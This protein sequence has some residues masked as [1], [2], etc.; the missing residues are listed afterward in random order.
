[1]RLSFAVAATALA[2]AVVAGSAPAKP[3]LPAQVKAMKGIELAV[4]RGSIDRGSAATYRAAVNRAARLIRNLP[5]AR[6]APISAALNQVAAMS[7]KL[8]APRAKAVFGQLA[9]NSSYFASKGPPGDGA[10]VRDADGVVYRYFSGR[11]L[12]FHP[13]ANFGALNSA[14]SRGY[15][16]SATRLA[17][18][19]IER[20]VGVPGGGK[21]WEYYF[22]YSGGRAP[23][24]SGM[25]QAVAAQAIASVAGLNEEKSAAFMAAARGAYRAI[26]GRLV[27]NSSSGLWVKLYG[28][29]RLTVLNAQ[30]QAV[31]SLGAYADASGDSAVY[32]MAS[33]LQ[34]SAAAALSRFDTGYWSYYALPS[35][36]S[37]L[38]YQRYVVQMLNQLRGSD[39]R[40]DSAAIRFA[41]YEKQPPAFKL[42]NTN[43]G[44]VRFWLSKPSSVEMKSGAGRTKRYLLK[45]GWYKL[46]WKLPKKAGAYG[47]TVSARDWASNSASFSS[48]PIVRTVTPS[49]KVWKVK[50]KSLISQKKTIMDAAEAGVT[51]RIAATT[52]TLGQPS[53]SV[54]AGL[55]DPSQVALASL[56]G[57]NTARYS[58]TWPGPS[59]A[60]PDPALVESLRANP[61]DKR[62][63]AELVVDPTLLTDDTAIAALAGYARS[64]AEQLPTIGDLLIGPAP[65]NN[66]TDLYVNVLGAI[67]DAV[68]LVAP[69][70]RVAGVIDGTTTPKTTLSSLGSSYG[71]SGRA[72]P[73]M[74]ELAFRPAPALQNGDWTIDNYS[75]LTT[76]LTSAFAGTAQPVSSLPILVDGVATVTGIPPE[77]VALYP[78]LATGTDEGTQ[79]TAYTH[80]LQAAV[81]MPTVSGVL[82]R[83]LVDHPGTAEQPN[84][85]DQSGLYYADGTAKSSADSLR[86]TGQSAQRGILRPCPGV[87]MPVLASTL[88]FPLELPAASP[89]AVLLACTRDCLYLV[90]LER[91]DGKPVRAQRG[92][93]AGGPTPTTVQLPKGTALSSSTSYRLRVRLVAQHN[94]GPLKQ[95]MSPALSLG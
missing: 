31:L 86:T 35:I 14:V 74:D 11:C 66:T 69:A 62:V 32:E 51:G 95:Y 42:A 55:N 88:V 10:D 5:R 54:G 7:G 91:S 27:M 40:F 30:L 37:T 28:F 44:T 89:P 19:L 18:A 83:R 25:A 65:A 9:L 1:M 47:V 87:A 92:L 41:S 56:Q 20:A 85:S 29:N 43:D 78:S 64:L 23:W 24:L 16:N 70:T 57:M 39:P 6:S 13:L 22:D 26:P 73:I 90:T 45:G 36:P 12:E 76:T 61:P 94:P 50:S 82:F 59:A 48:L 53:F 15:V 8:N 46:G 4:K 49:S 34:E 21:T 17:E 71:Y 33:A 2:M 67:Y 68:K 52:A 75:Q 60:T 93:L 72:A 3:T 58:L 80:A 77:K 84:S 38:S 81:C 63:V 79:A